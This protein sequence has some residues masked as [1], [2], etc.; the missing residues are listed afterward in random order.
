MQN[1]RS[2]NSAYTANYVCDEPRCRGNNNGDNQT[3]IQTLSKAARPGSPPNE[4][5]AP[6]DPERGFAVPIPRMRGWFTDLQLV[7]A[8]DRFC[9][10][11]ARNRVRSRTETL[12]RASHSPVPL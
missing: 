1:N 10:P 7:L 5:F 3:A 9:R 11:E 8:G 12:C 2:M 6:D 4:S